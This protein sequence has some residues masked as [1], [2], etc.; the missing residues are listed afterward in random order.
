MWG[1]T[2]QNSIHPTLGR[3]NVNWCELGLFQRREQIELSAQSQADLFFES[4]F[5]RSVAG[6]EWT[7]AQKNKNR[8]KSEMKYKWWKE[9]PAVFIVFWGSQLSESLSKQVKRRKLNCFRYLIYLALCFHSCH[10]E[11]DFG[12]AAMW[13]PSNVQLKIIDGSKLMRSNDDFLS[14]HCLKMWFLTMVV[15]VVVS[16]Q[17]WGRMNW[18][19]I[20]PNLWLMRKPCA[21]DCMRKRKSLFHFSSFIKVQCSTKTST[22][23]LFQTAIDDMTFLLLH[24]CTSQADH[25]SYFPGCAHITE[26]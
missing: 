12:A 20:P 1:A 8:S 18:A 2:L 14:W 6:L 4:S 23:T 24:M 19:F 3:W 15:N 13:R 16:F 22:Y 21:L 11:N 5:R 26:Q 25:W 17:Q 10:V 7:T 9:P